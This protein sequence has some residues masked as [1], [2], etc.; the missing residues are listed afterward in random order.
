VAAPCLSDTPQ[1][2]NERFDQDVGRLKTK[3]SGGVD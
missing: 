3:L 1:H 2:H